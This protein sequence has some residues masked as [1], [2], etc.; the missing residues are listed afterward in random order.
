MTMSAAD[1]YDALTPY[2]H[3][4]YGNWDEA[5]ENQAT[6][7][8]SIIRDVWGE[9]SHR[10]LD[11]A[12][13]IGT[14]ALGLARLY[15]D[16]TASDISPKQ[17]ERAQ[18][19][20]NARELAIQFSVADMLDA[21]AQHPGMFNVVLACDNALLHLM[22]EHEVHRAFQQF[23]ACTEPGGGCL[24]SVAEPEA[25][26]EPQLQPCA[27]RIVDGVRWVFGQVWEPR[28]DGYDVTLYV[29]QDKGDDQ[30]STVALRSTQYAVSIDRLMELMADAGFQDVQRIDDRYFQP[31]ITG[32]RKP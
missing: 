3:L 1:F 14:Q 7:L 2:Y 28:S 31:V 17:V 13:G 24:V 12:C 32:T 6:K 16:V 4:I 19:E 10:L 30:C 9:E 25:I 11:V 26:S 15:Y 20:A 18:A 22:S 23:F 29:I 27:V 8:D 21:D 5:I